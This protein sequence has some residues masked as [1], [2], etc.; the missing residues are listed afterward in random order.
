MVGKETGTLATRAM[1]LEYV[2][3][4]N[5]DQGLQE[6]HKY[7]AVFVLSFLYL[8]FPAL[9]HSDSFA[10]TSLFLRSSTTE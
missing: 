7:E 4:T 6:L 9:Y 2:T 8:T 10:H 3:I 5:A 1:W